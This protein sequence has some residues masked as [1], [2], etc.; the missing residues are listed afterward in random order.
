MEQR[1][2][3][4]IVEIKC[5]TLYTTPQVDSICIMADLKQ[6]KKRGEE[7]E[8]WVDIDVDAEEG[9]LMDEDD[10]EICLP[11]VELC[12][13]EEIDVETVPDENIEYWL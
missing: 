1:L 4:D 11:D 9:V 2:K 3:E 12:E 8:D 7:A 13:E 6:K 10:W 5:E